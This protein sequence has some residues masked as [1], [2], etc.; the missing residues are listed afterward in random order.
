MLSHAA[1]VLAQPVLAHP[2]L[3]G[4]GSVAQPGTG[5]R[6]GVTRG[7][8]LIIVVFLVVLGI[9]IGI[10]ELRR[11]HGRQGPDPRNPQSHQGDRTTDRRGRPGE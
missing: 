4:Y 2:S 5:G 10:G 8:F 11:S 3:L 9:M 6:L 7:F 1:A